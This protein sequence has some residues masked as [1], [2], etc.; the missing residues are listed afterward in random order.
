M[1]KNFISIYLISGQQFSR[2]LIGS[3]NSEYP[4]LFT[5][6]GRESKWRLVSRKFYEAAAPAMT[7]RKS[8]EIWLVDVYCSVENFRTPE[9]ATKL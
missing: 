5:V 2:V 7:R 6:L 1:V 9:F 4:S 8:D 3:R